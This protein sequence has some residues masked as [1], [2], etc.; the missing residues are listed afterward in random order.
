MP[1]WRVH[2]IIGE[3][4]CNFY[5]HEIDKLIDLT[6]KH[7]AGRYDSVI[8]NEDLEYVFKRWGTEGVCY[9]ILHHVLDRLSDIIVSELQQLCEAYVFGKISVEEAY[10]RLYENSF[11]RLS[12]EVKN[13]VMTSDCIKNEVL[14]Y[15]LEYILATLKSGWEGVLFYVILDTPK[16]KRPMI[17]KRVLNVMAVKS[18]AYQY[19]YNLKL[20]ENKVK[21]FLLKIGEVAARK[22]DDFLKSSH[23]RTEELAKKYE[24]REALNKLESRNCTGV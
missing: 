12:A 10:N 18:A 11:A 9:Y 7:D 20:D 16:G 4:V 23:E 2:R 21:E 5:N 14:T 8:L 3:I 22:F 6:G 24:L 15:L 1:S 17:A 19:K 13:F